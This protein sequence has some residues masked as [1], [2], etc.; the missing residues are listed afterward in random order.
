MSLSLSLRFT[1]TLRLLNR[2]I[3][4]SAA[5]SLLGFAEDEKFSI[6]ELRHAYYEAAKRCHPDV[7]RP[8]QS[9]GDGDS[10]SS[11]DFRDIT[12]A[13]E[14]LLG[15]DHS[16]Q[17]SKEELANIVSISED[18]EYR[19]ACHAKLGLPAEIVEE[20]KQNPMFRRWLT[21]NTDAAHHWR[22]F[23]AAHGGLIPKLRPPAGYLEHG[24]ERA[25]VMKSETRRKKSRK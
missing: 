4:T 23:F 14:H 15:G 6:R 25:P 8:Q 5:K 21:G 7:V 13:Y 24:G 10:D 9:G 18:E 3:S 1:P 17:F 20:S 19:L 2:G 11:L 12:E 16:S 22:S